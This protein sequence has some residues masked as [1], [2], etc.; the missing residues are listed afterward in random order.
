MSELAI[1]AVGYNRPRSL[2]RL[3][4]SLHAAEYDGDKVPLII[5]IDHSGN[6]EVAAVAEAFEWRHGEKQVV[7]QQER[8]GLRKHIIRCG[9]YSLVYGGVIVLEDDLFVSPWFY[10]YTKQALQKYEHESRI[11]GIS[12][13]SHLWNVTS[14]RPFQPVED[15]TDAYFFQFAQSW[16][17]AWSKQMWSRFIAWYEQQ[18]DTVS[19]Q[20]RLPHSVVQWPESSWLKYF[21]KYLVQSGKFFVY[22][23]ISLTTNFGDIGQH[24]K[25]SSTSYQVPLQYGLKQTF[26]FPDFHDH[27]VRYDVFF[28]RI[29]LGGL[30]AVPDEELCV[31]LYGE[32]GKDS[33]KRY[34]LT[35][36]QA[37]YRKLASYGLQLRPHEMNVIYAIPGDDLYL[38]DTHE[39]EHQF[40]SRSHRSDLLKSLYDIR[41]IHRKEIV[42]LAVY[43][44][45]SAIKRK[46]KRMSV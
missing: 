39:Q 9:N 6:K 15:G 28:E 1:V 20:D 5:S 4:Q 46:L 24:A 29:G 37:E 3:L 22:P 35:M 12:L 13:Y 26:H 32:K 31:D 36:E 43:H 23:R 33:S 42:R 45:T 40:A 2:Q 34:W 21:I 8:L 25:I 14:D 17:Q 30:C 18:E 16:G 11:A 41:A 44:I 19:S 10:Q 38:Y 7:V 27:A